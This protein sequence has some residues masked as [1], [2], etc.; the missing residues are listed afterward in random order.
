MKTS[1]TLR[2][3][4]RQI[5]E[6]PEL[7]PAFEDTELHVIQLHKVEEQNDYYPDFGI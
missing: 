5:I 2:V 3:V 7:D 6:K 4:H 1:S